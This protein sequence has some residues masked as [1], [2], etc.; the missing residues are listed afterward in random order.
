[1]K[2]FRKDLIII[3]HIIE[4]QLNRKFFHYG[5][6]LITSKVSD[7]TKQKMN[8]KMLPIITLTMIQQKKSNRN[9]S[10]INSPNEKTQ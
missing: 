3:D 5:V 10:V 7:F 4:N 2:F 8:D 6:F 9:T 1:M